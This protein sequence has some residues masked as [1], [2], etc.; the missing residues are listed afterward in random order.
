VGF[1]EVIK[2]VPWETRVVFGA[3]VSTRMDMLDTGAGKRLADPIL[4]IYDAHARTMGIPEAAIALSAPILTSFTMLVIGCPPI[5][6]IAFDIGYFSLFDFITVA[7]PWAI[8]CLI[9]VLLGASIYR[10]LT[11]PRP[12]RCWG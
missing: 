7:E 10:P 3:S 5:T 9:I 1:N 8:V 2:K 11:G 4:L 12:C 6:S